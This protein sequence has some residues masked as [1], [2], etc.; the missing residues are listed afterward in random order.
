MPKTRILIAE[1]EVIVAESLK[2]VLQSLEYEVLPPCYNYDQAI[3]LLEK[4]QA[5]LALLDIR[6]RNSK[7]GIEIAGYVRRHKDMPIIFLSANSDATTLERAKGV[8]PDAFLV[9]PFQ[10]T[11]LNVAIEIAISNF[12]STA[13]H[14]TGPANKGPYH[15]NDVLYIKE[16]GYFHKIRV[17]DVYYLS[18]N[19]VYV[20]IHT[21]DKNFL[22][23][24]SLGDYLE[25]LNPDRF[26]RVHQR[27]AVN[28]DK[29]D[30]VHPRHLLINNQEIPVS[31]SYNDQL[32]TSLKLKSIPL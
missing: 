8:K 12:T 26:I 15:A 22:V 13:T 23:R 21:K 24:S 4:E 17:D 25:K 5:D 28:M 19:H 11:N 31:K 1:D 3:T 20:T 27:Y 18:S 32:F 16:G 9:K 2:I 10:K 6:L 7:D 29:V 14:P 30:K